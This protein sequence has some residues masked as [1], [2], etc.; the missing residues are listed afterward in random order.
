M[1]LV[2]MKLDSS[3][4]NIVG[5]LLDIFVPKRSMRD[6]SN[7]VFPAMILIEHL[8]EVWLVG[9]GEGSGRWCYKRIHICYKR[10]HICIRNLAF[11][12]MQYFFL[13]CM[14]ILESL[15]NPWG[16][17]WI[18]DVTVSLRYMYSNL[19][20]CEPLFIMVVPGQHPLNNLRCRIWR[21]CCQR[22]ASIKINLVSHNPATFSFKFENDSTFNIGLWMSRFPPF[23][24]SLVN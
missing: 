19:P 6:R 17:L 8:G 24:F 1:T 15:G 20:F 4:R 14:G 23:N 12:C 2:L 5:Q 10:I 3:L 18:Q 9:R 22:L 16:T 7:K 13:F 11:T 21:I